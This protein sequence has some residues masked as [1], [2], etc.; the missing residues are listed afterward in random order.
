MPCGIYN[1]LYDSCWF[2]IVLSYSLFHLT[3]SKSQLFHLEG[4]VLEICASPN[5]LRCRATFWQV[6]VWHARRLQPVRGFHELS[7]KAIIGRWNFHVDALVVNN[8]RSNGLSS[9]RYTVYNCCRQVI[10]K[11]DSWFRFNIR[12]IFKQFCLLYSSPSS[13]SYVGLPRH[14]ARCYGTVRPT[15]LIC[16]FHPSWTVSLR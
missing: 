2:I 4:P 8:S 6:C 7:A 15:W 11:N 13:S 12:N 1:V 9:F 3:Q 14:V 5:Y 10:I 16:L